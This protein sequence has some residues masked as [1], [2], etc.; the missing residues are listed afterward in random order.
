MKHRSTAQNLILSGHVRLNGK[1]VEKV[2]LAV[3]PDD[4]LTIVLPQGVRVV[5]V[6]A[7]PEKRGS[8]GQAQMLYRDTSAAQKQDETNL[9]LC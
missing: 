1:R 4:I 2:S 8:A 3:K 7:E 9:A 5:T 6:L